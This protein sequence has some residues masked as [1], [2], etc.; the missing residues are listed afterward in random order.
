VSR[1][2]PSPCDTSHRRAGSAG[3]MRAM[4]ARRRQ[5]LIVV[6]LHVREAEIAAL[7]RRR[8]LAPEARHDRWA[9]ARALGKLLDQWRLGS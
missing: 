3:R 2:D 8:L 7:V 4:R 1:P 5:G 6:P 9:I